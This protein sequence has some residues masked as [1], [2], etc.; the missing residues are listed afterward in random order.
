MR[1]QVWQLYWYMSEVWMFLSYSS[2]RKNKARYFVTWL[3]DN[4]SSHRW[5]HFVMLALFTTPPEPPDVD[6]DDSVTINER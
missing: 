6:D 4:N 5:K 3:F 2:F 1:R